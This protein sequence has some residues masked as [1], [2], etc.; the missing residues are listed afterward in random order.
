MNIDKS[1]YYLWSRIGEIQSKGED[2]SKFD[3]LRQSHPKEVH[4]R[5]TLLGLN[6][7]K[8]NAP[9]TWT[10]V[11]DNIPITQTTTIRADRKGSYN[12]SYHRKGYSGLKPNIKIYQRFIPCINAS[13]ISNSEI[14]PGFTTK[15][16]SIM[17]VIDKG[18]T[19]DELSPTKAHTIR[20][21]SAI[22]YYTILL[23]IQ[24]KGN[25]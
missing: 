23:Q 24:V 7:T 8:S 17:E 21:K 5:I 9:E 3:E 11:E 15:K 20:S 6:P 19:M 22:L 10:V 16:R 12:T 2:N 14:K 18:V 1:Y 13:P 25:H 4:I